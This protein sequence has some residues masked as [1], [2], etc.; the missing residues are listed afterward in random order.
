MIKAVSAAV[1]AVVTLGC[2][3]GAHAQAPVSVPAIL[4]LSGA[5][6]FLGKEEQ[7]AMRLGEALINASGGIN[8][9]P[10]KFEYYDDQ[11]KPQVA[12]QLLQQILATKPPVILGAATVANCSATMP[13]MTGGPVMYCLS[14]TIKPEAGSYVFTSNVSTDDADRAIIRYFRMRGMTRIGLVTA[15][16]AMG[17]MAERSIEEA[18][19]LP[20]NADVKIVGKVNFDPTDINITAQLISLKATKP[21]ALLAWNTGAPIGTV[22]RGLLDTGFEVPVATNYGNMTYAQMKAY[23]AFLPK[24]LYF[25]SAEWLPHPKSV[26]LNPEVETAQRAFFERFAAANIKPD[27]GHTMVWDPMMIVASA[28]RA[29]G[30]DA[31]AEAVRDHLIK[32]QGYY[33]VN[34]AYDFK[35]VPQRGLSDEN[36]VISRWNASAKTWDVVSRPTGIPLEQ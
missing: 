14:P 17:Q 5:G 28:L 8:G 7:E 22:M 31:K 33:G 1:L 23:E 16:D 27:V 2:W 34:G 21:D 30:P 24:E 36:V 10:V 4:P 3:S 20:E 13:L 11:S 18:L 19:K 15:T 29:A 6:A 32:V 9:R 25:S 35:A 26:S 12:V